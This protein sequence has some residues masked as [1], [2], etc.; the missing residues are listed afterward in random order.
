MGYRVDTLCSRGE[1]DGSLIFQKDCCAA[2]GQTWTDNNKNCNT[3]GRTDTG[4][5]ATICPN[6]QLAP[7]IKK[8]DG[9]AWEPTFNHDPVTGAKAPIVSRSTQS[10]CPACATQAGSIWK[11]MTTTKGAQT[12]VDGRKYSNWDEGDLSKQMIMAEDVEAREVMEACLEAVNGWFHP[13][14]HY[15]I[16]C[17]HTHFHSEFQAC[18]QKQNEYEEQA[19]AWRTKENEYCDDYKN[20]IET[21]KRACRQG[22]ELCTS[23]ET[24]VLARKADYETGQRIVCLLAVLIGDDDGYNKQQTN[25]DGTLSEPFRGRAVIYASKKE[26]LE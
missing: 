5:A 23:L 26:R 13:L 16:K 6:E 3:L 8:D 11:K 15:Y 19:C 21:E 2:G 9:T 14:Y 1:Y 4:C 10:V 24:K 22:S 12:K 18:R 17:T 7:T 25:A 20:C